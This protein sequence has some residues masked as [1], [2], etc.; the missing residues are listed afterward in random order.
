MIV[1]LAPPTEAVPARARISMEE[2]LPQLVRR[3]AWAGD[4]RRGSV[5][6]ELGSGRY[7]G[8]VITVHAEEGRVR[9]QVEGDSELRERLE[10]RGFEVT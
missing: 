3:I 4:Q 8:T 2:L 9:V 1:S 6:L 7:A 10:A 5:Q